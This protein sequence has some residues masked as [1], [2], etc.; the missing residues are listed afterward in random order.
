[1][2]NY[3]GY[4]ERCNGLDTSSKLR[5]ALGFQ[6]SEILFGVEG[7]NNQAKLINC[8]LL[9]IR[10]Y[11]LLFT[12]LEFQ[13]IYQLQMKHYSIFERCVYL[14]KKNWHKHNGKLGSL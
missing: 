13:E 14:K 11:I 3:P 9:C 1:M 12:N 5:I 2:W 10:F 4:F 7:E 8:V 6:P